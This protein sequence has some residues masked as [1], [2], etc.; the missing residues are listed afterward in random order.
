MSDKL[1]ANILSP[2]YSYYLYIPVLYPYAN[3]ITEKT[4]RPKCSAGL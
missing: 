3:L 1:N 2:Y 4:K